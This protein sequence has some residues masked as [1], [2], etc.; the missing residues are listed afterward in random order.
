MKKTITMVLSLLMVLSLAACGGQT[1]KP[2]ESTQQTKQTEN[3]Q[4]NEQIETTTLEASETEL[5]ETEELTAAETEP[6]FDT[7]WASNEFEAMLPELPF[8]GW[9][10]TKEDDRTYKMELGG[11]NTSPATNP[12]DSGEPDGADKD[13]LIEYLNSLSDYGFVV[14]ETSEGYK[15]LVTDSSGNTMEFMCAEGFCWITIQKTN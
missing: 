10:T 13:K 9:T 8:T 4:F 1:D 5:Q 2:A 7:S 6:A 15:W 12:P 11:L 14:E 3:N